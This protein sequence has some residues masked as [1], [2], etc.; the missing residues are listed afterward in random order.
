MPLYLPAGIFD[1]GMHQL[2]QK[3]SIS[4]FHL[5]DLA[6][7]N[8]FLLTEQIYFGSGDVYRPKGFRKRRSRHSFF[9][10]AAYRR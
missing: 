8:K 3:R 5:L 2:L 6:E 9:L 10:K 1:Q 7:E 4:E